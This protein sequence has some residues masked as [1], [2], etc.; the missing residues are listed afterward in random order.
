MAESQSGSLFA[1]LVVSVTM[2]TALAAQCEVEEELAVLSVMETDRL[3]SH[4]YM[5]GESGSRCC[6]L[7]WSF[8]VSPDAASFHLTFLITSG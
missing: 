3:L 5:I 4:K 2:A 8:N 1:S 6:A 7:H